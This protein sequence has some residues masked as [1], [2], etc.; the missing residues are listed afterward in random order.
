MKIRILAMLLLIA[1]CLKAQ[2]VAKSLTS[3]TGLF[4]GYYEYKPIDYNVDPSVKYPLII[5]LHG[6][7][8]KGNGTTELNRVLTNAI[9]KYINAGSTMSFTSLSGVRETFLVLSPQL[10]AMYGSWQNVYVDEML[11]YAKANLRIDTNRIFLTGLS[12]GG[13][14]TW[15]YAT[16]SSANAR[17][18]AAIAPVCGTCEWSNLCNLATANVPVWAFHAQDDGLVGVGCTDGAISMLQSCSPAIAPIK[19]IYP[20]GNHWI[21]DQSYDTTHN[22]HNPSVFE[23]FLGQSRNSP[24]N[25][26]PIANV[27]PDKV[28]TLPLNEVLL[29]S[30]SSSDPDGTIARIKWRMIQS[31]GGGWI[32]NPAGITTMAKGLSQGIYKFEL[33]VVDNRAG[34]SSD[35]LTVT[36]NPTS[37]NIP[38]IAAAGSD[39]VIVTP[40]VSLDASLS[41]DPDGYVAAYNWRQIS[42][43]LSATVS[44]A[45]CPNPGLTGL[46]SIGIYAMEVTV[47]DNIGA[48]SK[49]TVI[50]VESNLLLPVSF[51]YFKGKSELGHNLLQWATAHE[52]NNMRFELERSR[53]GKAYEKIGVIAGAGTS[54]TP[55]EYRFTDINPST[56]FNY[57]RLKQVDTENGF[58]YSSIVQVYNDYDKLEVQTF[59]NPVTNELQVSLSRYDGLPMRIG[60]RNQHGQL[61]KQFNFQPAPGVFRTKIDAR[62]LKPGIYFIE[63]EAGQGTKQVSKFIKN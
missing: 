29:N 28:I 62:N 37:A 19:S 42:G 39:A 27:G 57:Y 20:T 49:D 34:W 50:I 54:A 4:I 32:E 46:T 17:Q 47:T 48:I 52:L 45:N 35:T 44:C 59:P 40:S 51:T 8:E 2:Q 60:L 10:N 15:K 5:F 18:F 3:S 58:K 61:L 53:D 12:L 1:P 24:I 7:G 6:V 63:V 22:W 33:T 26:K 13:G 56:G 9:P 36:V 23:W 14:G 55:K 16:A 43:P 25:S 41:Y 31:P 11:K 21:W 30:T 38:P